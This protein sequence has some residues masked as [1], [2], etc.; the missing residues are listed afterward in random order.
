MTASG[1][2]AHL[3]RGCFTLRELYIGCRRGEKATRGKSEPAEIY[4][5]A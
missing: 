5:C 2:L 4:T 3:E 1:M